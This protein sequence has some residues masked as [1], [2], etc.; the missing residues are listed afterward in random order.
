[1]SE[2]AP[3]IEE[4]GEPLTNQYLRRPSPEI[5]ELSARLMA[6][7]RTIEE[8]VAALAAVTPN[9]SDI[10]EEITVDGTGLATIP[11]RIRIDGTV[12]RTL[13][14]TTVRIPRPVDGFEYRTRYQNGAVLPHLAASIT[15]AWIDPAGAEIPLDPADYTYDSGT[16]AIVLASLDDV[17]LVARGASSGAWTVAVV[18]E[19]DGARSLPISSR[20]PSSR[21]LELHGHAAYGLIIGFASA[22]DVAVPDHVERSTDDILPIGP[23]PVTTTLRLGD[24]VA[25]HDPLYLDSARLGRRLFG[26]LAEP[27]ICIGLAEKAGSPGEKIRAIFK[28][29]LFDPAWSWDDSVS[30]IWLGATGGLT[31]TMPTTGRLLQVASA[32]SRNK[33]MVDVGRIDLEL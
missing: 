16:G 5:V 13:A 12:I 10:V 18:E 32:I 2:T 23:Q 25:R 21:D 29:E 3:I 22:A 8:R 14:A 20:D 26:N 17:L 6:E 11:R 27:A 31:A 33:L 15:L 30:E 9:G 19:L 24:F 7:I 1:M 28:G 4:W